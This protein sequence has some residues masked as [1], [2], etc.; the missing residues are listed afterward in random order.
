MR[1]GGGSGV[2]VSFY[3]TRRTNGWRTRTMWFARLVGT[4]EIIGV[5]QAGGSRYV[6]TPHGRRFAAYLR[7]WRAD[8]MAEAERRVAERV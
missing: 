6:E 5:W 7:D 3:R 2:C 4:P 1:P 8:C